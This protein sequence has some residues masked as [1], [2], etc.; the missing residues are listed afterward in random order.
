LDNYFSFMQ[1]EK[2]ANSELFKDF[3]EAAE[4]EKKCSNWWDLF[5]HRSLSKFTKKQ[6]VAFQ[7]LLN[8][9]SC[10]FAPLV[11]HI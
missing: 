2:S 1:V 11:F 10:R 3:F 9:D 5:C 6:K 4:M 7:S 8:T